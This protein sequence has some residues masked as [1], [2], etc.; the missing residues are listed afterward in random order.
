[1][2]RPED[3]GS[4]DPGID[5][6]TIHVNDNTFLNGGVLANVPALIDQGDP[7]RPVDA[8]GN[9][10]GTTDV[11]TIQNELTGPAYFTPFLNS[12]TDTDPLTDGFQGDFSSL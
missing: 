12:G 2:L 8:S 5:G 3:A 6:T 1:R 9:W 4:S 10:W 7:A 11:P